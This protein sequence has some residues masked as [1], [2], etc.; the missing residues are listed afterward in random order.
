MLLSTAYLPPIQWF[1]KL[2][3]TEQGSNGA[4]VYVEALEIYIK[5]TY[6]NRCVIDS[7]AG[8]L[9]LTI[10]VEKPDNGSRLIRD[11]RI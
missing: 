11:L 4:C 10:P 7:S 2:L 3:G 6:R 5:Q 9:A 8:P 1:T